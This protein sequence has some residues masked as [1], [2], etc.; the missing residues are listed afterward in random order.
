MKKSLVTQLKAIF[1]VHAFI[2]SVVETKNNPSN[3]LKTK[4][5]DVDTS[6]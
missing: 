4:A 5:L 3:A 2:I 1:L 6:P